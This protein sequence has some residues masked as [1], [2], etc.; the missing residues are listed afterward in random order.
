M[1]YVKTAD[2]NEETKKWYNNLF[3]KKKPEV[4][5]RYGR[6]SILDGSWEEQI[7]LDDNGFA[8]CLSISRDFGGTIYFNPSI[9]NSDE[10]VIFGDET[11][12]IHF[13]ED[14]ARAFGFEENDILRTLKCAVSM[15]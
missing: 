9:G 6:Q 2:L 1:V 8:R 13:S 7:T 15:M 14:K 11:R 5:T 3:L 10:I 12:C 4:K